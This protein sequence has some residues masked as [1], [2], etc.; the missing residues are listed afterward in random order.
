MQHS[1][2]L[3]AFAALKEDDFI[4]KKCPNCGADLDEQAQ[5]CSK[6]GA[7]QTFDDDSMTLSE[8]DFSAPV[9][10]TDASQKSKSHVLMILIIAVLAVIIVGIGFLA[11]MLLLNPNQKEDSGDDTE[12]AVVTTTAITET[13]VEETTAETT[14]T[15]EAATTAATAAITPA[16]TEAPLTLAVPDVSAFQKDAPNGGDG[17]SYT[18][19]WSAV[20]DAEGYELYIGSC[21]PDYSSSWSYETKQQTNT[22]FSV[23]ASINVSYTCKVRAYA[24]ENGNVIYSDWS[25]TQSVELCPPS[26]NYSDFAM[27][28]QV[29]T[30]GGS[31]DGVTTAYVYGNSGYEVQHHVQNTWHITAKSS[32]YS[33]GV[34]WYECWDTDDGDYY[35]WIDSNYI[36]FY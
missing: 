20:A 13:T 30:H 23:G 29:N 34:L 25:A 31:V 5:F 21:E 18:M 24:H 1:A 16:P 27:R 17:E 26:D 33:N 8:P 7:V 11:A 36:D 2:I 32:Y 12:K 28:G 6:C 35:G 3:C 15:T 4:M 9:Q 14:T 19:S 10:P 22:I